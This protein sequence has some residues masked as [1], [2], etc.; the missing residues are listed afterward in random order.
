MLGKFILRHSSIGIEW[1]GVNKY[2]L[3]SRTK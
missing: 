1:A 3:I 2:V